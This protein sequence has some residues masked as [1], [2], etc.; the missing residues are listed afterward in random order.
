MAGSDTPEG[1]SRSQLHR[2]T[3]TRKI[4]AVLTSVFLLISVIFLILVGIGGTYNKAVIRNFYFLKLDLSHIVPTS[5]PNSVLINSIAQSLGLHDF[6]QV[7]LWGFCEGYNGEGVT[8]C[9][10]PRVLYWFNPVQILR[11]ELLA[12]ASIALPANINDILNLI[13][14]A[15]EVMFGLFLTG[16]C[17]STILIFLTP[18]S[19]YSRWAAFPIAIFTFLT[20]L[21]TTT[22]SIIATVMFVIFRNV[23]GSVAEVNIGAAIGNKM[24]AFMWVASAFSIF[25]WLIQTGLCCCCTSRRDVKTGRKKGNEKAYAVGGNS[26]KLTVRR[27]FGF[28]RKKQASS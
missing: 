1:L 4:F 12:G 14:I 7:G 28:G 26:E 15:S 6:Y 27:R 16:A 2:A 11:N 18:L 17:L 19:V 10:K 24:F 13:K 20:A 9:S 25:A 5:V 3:H 23:I 22:A 8:H 21:F